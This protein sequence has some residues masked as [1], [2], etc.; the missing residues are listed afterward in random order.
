MRRSLDATC[1]AGDHVV[2]VFV[3]DLEPGSCALEL[4]QLCGCQRNVMREQ[5]KMRDAVV[6][7][8]LK[9]LLLDNVDLSMD[10]VPRYHGRRVAITIPRKC[11]GSPPSAPCRVLSLSALVAR[12]LDRP[13]DARY[14]QQTLADGADRRHMARTRT[15]ELVPLTPNG[16]AAAFA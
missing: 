9:S 10:D 11:C 6:I 12:K 4:T 8:E 14:T 7:E 16:A 1:E 13:E 3:L 5:K 2:A 15:F